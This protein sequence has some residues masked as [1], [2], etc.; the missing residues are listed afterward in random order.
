M[1]D[2]SKILLSAMNTDG[3]Y[4]EVE[5]PEN[6]HSF[7]AAIGVTKPSPMA[8]NSISP[9]HPGKICI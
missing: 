9:D 1:S 8:A 5:H 6:R 7:A 3:M 4:G 2:T